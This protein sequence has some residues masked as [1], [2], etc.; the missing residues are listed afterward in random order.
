MDLAER[1]NR[2]AQAENLVPELAGQGVVAIATT[3][4][5]NSGIARVKAVPTHRLPELAAWGVGASTSFDRFRFD[6]LVVMP[7]T[8][9]GPVGDS[10]MI[11]DLSR[12]VTLQAQPGWAWAPG[13]RY[14]QDGNPHEQC[15]RVLLRR[16]I[17]QLASD[18][19][20]VQAG[21][22]IEWAVS[23]GDG[24]E[25]QP[26]T[27]GPAYG[28]TRLSELSDYCRDVISALDAEGVDVEQLHPEYGPGQFEVSYA[29]ASP[30]DA[31]DTSVLVRSTI[32]AVGHRHGLRTSYSAKVQS[33]GVGNGGHVHLSLWRD[34]DNLMS[35][36]ESA[37]GLTD[38]GAA[39]AAGILARLPGLLAIGAPGV[40]SYLRLVPSHW[41][42]AYACWGLEN[43]EAALRMVTGSTGSTETAANIEV[44][45]FDLQA[46]P[47][48]LLSGL[49]VAGLAGL[50]DNAV[51]P[52]PVD[53]DPAVLSASDLADRQ[54]IRLPES[55]QESLDAFL[56]DDILTTAFGSA[57]VGSIAAV[58]RSEIDLFAGAT[59]DVIARATRWCH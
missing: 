39:F 33:A 2:R 56:A 35:G 6:D 7:A 26:A 55:L 10:R 49:L 27:T 48:L 32:R 31:A 23:R 45:C 53:V 14:D 59:A 58:R 18:G 52:D 8:G 40:A 1:Q 16:V 42:G 22:E 51:L 38:A 47:Y 21:I 13:E 3:F 24:D 37:L 46:N 44:K 50:A 12:L 57:L 36:G 20:S 15:S 9:E 54:I 30:V 25:L 34:G 4:V 41:A 11:P 43:R 28:M 29:A 5:D 17:D 19:L